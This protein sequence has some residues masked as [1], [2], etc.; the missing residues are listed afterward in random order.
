MYDV[1]GSEALVAREALRPPKDT[2]PTEG[3]IKPSP[4]TTNLPSSSANPS[5]L[6]HSSSLT[7]PWA[8]KDAASSRAEL[9]A[10]QNSLVQQFTSEFPNLRLPSLEDFYRPQYA[11]AL[12]RFGQQDFE[13]LC[14][15]Q[16]KGA[17]GRIKYFL[18][19]EAMF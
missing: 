10:K 16:K 6:P 15:A 2:K 19:F 17:I 11:E 8:A 14:D 18:F 12:Q 13:L 7:S 3:Q 9:V 1:D 5:S 4:S